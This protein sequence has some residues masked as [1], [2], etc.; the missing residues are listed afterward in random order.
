VAPGHSANIHVPHGLF[1]N[2]FP[3]PFAQG[4][5][6]G[7]G[8]SYSYTSGAHNY[9]A[10]EFYIDHAAWK[11]NRSADRVNLRSANWG[12]DGGYGAWVHHYR[13]EGI[14]FNGMRRTP[15]T[16]NGTAESA[17]VAAW[18]SGEASS[19]QSCYFV[20]FEKD[21]IL[22]VRGTPVA[23]YNCS[24]FTTSRFGIAIVG[25]GSVSCYNIS[26]DESGVALVGSIPGYGRP[27]NT[28]LAVFGGKQE[29]STSGE[30]R[31]W[32]GSSFLYAEGWIT[33][34]IHGVSFAS[35]WTTPYDFV[36]WKRDPAIGNW[37]SIKVTGT[38]SFGNAPRCLFYD[39]DGKEYRFEGNAWQ[40][41][42]QSWTWHE[43]QGLKTD[44]ATI[45][46]T[47]RTGTQGRL[48]HV[49]QDGAT[50]W[51][52]AKIYDPTGGNGGTVPP[53][54]P[55][56]VPTPCTYT[57][58][59]WSTC[60]N[61][62]QTRTVSATPA[63]CTGTPPAA[64]QACT[65]TP[66]PPAGVKGRW[67]FGSG[68]AAS[69]NSAVGPKLVLV[70][71]T[72][73]MSGGLIRNSNANTAW[74]CAIPGV[75]QVVLKGFVPTSLNYQLLLN[76]TG[77]RG[78]ILLPNGSVVDNTIQG[79]DKAVAPAG[80]FLVGRSYSGTLVLPVPMDVQRVGAGPNTGNAWQGTLDELELR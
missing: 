14:R 16:N 73:T 35:G 40:N 57:T 78:L 49:G 67:M 4:R 43:T 48:Q 45:T 75:T 30:F 50:D 61:G 56:P 51:S 47:I 3:M 29:T 25:G 70:A 12:V 63:G 44:W 20:D 19:I 72:A 5:Y 37:S 54:P 10:T 9:G 24:M 76:T 42:M 28:R 46:P 38:H 55:P 15:W 69:I 59:T 65:V 18:D 34:T 17:G 26:G 22:L 6:T 60:A 52:T 41:T 27:S 32:K 80:T 11:T 39:H 23:I 64:S 71:G 21:G 1:P 74:T 7:E 31:P 36:S 66:P 68:T 13:I 58:G 33:A 53:P 79:D 2:S 77:A 62:T 8:C